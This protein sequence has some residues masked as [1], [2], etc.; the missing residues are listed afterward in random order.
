MSGCPFLSSKKCTDNHV[1]SCIFR[2]FSEIITDSMFST[3]VKIESKEVFTASLLS[4]E[5]YGISTGEYDFDVFSELDRHY[6]KDIIKESNEV[7]LLLPFHHFPIQYNSLFTQHIHLLENL[8][9]SPLLNFEASICEFEL[10]QSRLSEM[11]EASLTQRCL[12]LSVQFSK[13]SSPEEKLELLN[14]IHCANSV[15]LRSSLWDILSFHFPSKILEST[16]TQSKIMKPEVSA[17]KIPSLANFAEFATA[18]VSPPSANAMILQINLP[19]EKH[20]AAISVMQFLLANPWPENLFAAESHFHGESASFF[21]L[22]LIPS[23]LTPLLP[24]RTF[25][26]L[27]AVQHRYTTL[28]KFQ[29]SLSAIQACM[30]GVILFHA[31]E[32]KRISIELL[33]NH[34]GLHANDIQPLMF[35]WTWPLSWV[36]FNS[37]ESDDTQRV[38]YSYFSELKLFWS[39]N[40]GVFH[41]KHSKKNPTLPVVADIIA[42]QSIENDFISDQNHENNIDEFTPKLLHSRRKKKSN[43]L[44]EKNP[45]R[46]MVHYVESKPIFRGNQIIQEGVQNVIPSTFENQNEHQVFDEREKQIKKIVLEPELHQLEEI[47]NLSSVSSSV[48]DYNE[49]EEDLNLGSPP[50]EVDEIDKDLSSDSENDEAT[51]NLFGNLLNKMSSKKQILKKENAMTKEMRQHFERAVNEAN[52]EVGPLFGEKTKLNSNVLNKITLDGKS[53]CN[54]Y[55]RQFSSPKENDN[56]FIFDDLQ[57]DPLTFGQVLEALPEMLPLKPFNS[58]KKKKLTYEAAADIIMQS[59]E[60]PIY[61][62]DSKASLRILHMLSCLLESPF[63]LLLELIPVTFPISPPLKAIL[64][65]NKNPDSSSNLLRV[66]QVVEAVRKFSYSEITAKVVEIVPQENPVERYLL[67]VLA[68]LHAASIFNADSIMSK[69]PELSINVRMDSWGCDPSPY[70]NPS[71]SKSDLSRLKRHL[72]IVIPHCKFK[73]GLSESI[74][75]TISHRV[76]INQ[77]GKVEKDKSLEFRHLCLNF[78][79]VSVHETL[80]KCKSNLAPKF[81]SEHLQKIQPTWKDVVDPIFVF[82]ASSSASMASPPSFIWFACNDLNLKWD[83]GRVIRETS[84]VI[85]L[86]LTALPGHINFCELVREGNIIELPV[87]PGSDINWKL[88]NSIIMKRVQFVICTGKVYFEGQT[89]TAVVI[90][91]RKKK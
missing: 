75:L 38:L 88:P 62:E 90:A 58:K 67:R 69:F 42:N 60:T 27:P 47:Y 53:A 49:N 33:A 51:N 74:A 89:E 39:K 14:A 50:V 1:S 3:F 40:G 6:V 8:I 52:K 35:L 22:N 31:L 7:K 68:S 24:S 64:E 77:N 65:K 29:D 85:I 79:A 70:I 44:N 10:A 84:P 16:I 36:E 28:I 43:L 32:T 56:F 45:D 12:L 13:K 18:P 9:M 25:A 15:V 37:R 34:I 19:P 86:T 78:D 20:T 4:H 81:Q 57:S 11:T 82:N 61:F 30:Q 2:H 73:S 23:P 48:S 83:F 17:G 71:T 55:L 26:P 72:E 63:R 21:D 66:L 5:A 80:T 54:D 46:Q 87:Y 59:S 76:S 41:K 91:S